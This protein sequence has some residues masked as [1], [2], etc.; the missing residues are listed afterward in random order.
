MNHPFNMNVP[1][2]AV[3]A[4][5]P[6]PTP[7]LMVTRFPSGPSTPCTPSLPHTPHPSP[8]P[9]TP[10]SPH[11]SP[12]PFLPHSP[13]HLLGQLH[14]LRH[15]GL[16]RKV[17]HYFLRYLRSWKN[18]LTRVILWLIHWKLRREKKMWKLIY[19]VFYHFRLSLTPW[20]VKTQWP[21]VAAHLVALPR[22]AT[23]RVVASFIFEFHLN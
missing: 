14:Q 5:V 8:S 21:H 11:A 18:M 3:S 12:T 17:R 20:I 10:H 6:V 4:N 16:R 19:K 7:P 23:P 1:Q 9:H 15:Q 2:S 22:V 13:I